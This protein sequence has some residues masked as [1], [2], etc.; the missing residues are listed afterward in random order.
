LRI[1]GA[2]IS[3]FPSWKHTKISTS[4]RIKKTKKKVKK[5]LMPDKLAMGF[6]CFFLIPFTRFGRF[7]SSRSLSS[8]EILFSLLSIPRADFFQFFFSLLFRLT[9]VQTQTAWR[10]VPCKLEKS[11]K[12]STNFHIF[13]LTTINYLSC[14]F[15]EIFSLFSPSRVAFCASF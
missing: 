6:R 15:D 4:L 2:A 12:F 3:L 13:H 1:C 11:L 10:F 8:F 14:K 7:Q 5:E 9:D